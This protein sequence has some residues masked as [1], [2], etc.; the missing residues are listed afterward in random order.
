MASGT[1]SVTS[2]RSRSAADTVPAS[3][4]VRT[5]ARNGAQ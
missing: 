4:I 5:M 3:T 2:I 1:E